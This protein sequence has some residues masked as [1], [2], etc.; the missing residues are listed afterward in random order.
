VTFPTGFITST[1]RTAAD[2]SE[3]NH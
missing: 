2:K 3:E 1:N